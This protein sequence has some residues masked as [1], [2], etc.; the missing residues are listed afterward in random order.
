[1]ICK[2]SLEYISNERAERLKRVNAKE[3]REKKVHSTQHWTMMEIIKMR[4]SMAHRKGNTII[5]FKHMPTIPT[6]KRA[7]PSNQIFT[8]KY[9]RNWN[10]HRRRRRRRP[11]FKSDLMDLNAHFL[12]R[13][14]FHFNIFCWL[15]STFKRTKY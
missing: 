13:V 7:P 14:P 15:F 3:E 12:K 4:T 8:T 6:Q 9:I 5:H 1:M 2:Q 10:S 11:F